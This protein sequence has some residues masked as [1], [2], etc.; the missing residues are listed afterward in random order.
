VDVG[1]DGVIA[2]LVISLGVWRQGVLLVLVIAPLLRGV[3]EVGTVVALRERLNADRAVSFLV[4]LSCISF[5]FAAPSLS[6]RI[7]SGAFLTFKSFSSTTFLG[8]EDCF[9]FMSILART[10]LIEEVVEFE[11]ADNSD[12]VRKCPSFGLA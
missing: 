11:T 7:F 4:V 1:L 5:S 6:D 3:D 10:V 9:G 12:P 2:D 8:E